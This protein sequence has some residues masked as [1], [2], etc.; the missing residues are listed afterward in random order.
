MSRDLSAIFNTRRF[1]SSDGVLIV[2]DIAGPQ[3]A[4]MVVLM[5]G[6]GQTRHSWSGTFEMLGNAGY[7][8]IA[9]DARGH[10]ESGWST[11]GSYSY[12]IRAADL[13]AVLADTSGPFV[14]VGASMG[15]VTGMQAVGE[16]VRPAALVLVDIV[17]APEKAGVDRIRNFMLGN[18]DGFANLEAVV[19]AVAAYSPHRPRPRNT[20]GLMR[21]LREGSDGRLRWH[22]DPR[23]LPPDS[24]DDLSRIEDVVAL[25]RSS[26]DSPLLLVRGMQSDVLSDASVA[27][28]LQSFPRAEVLDVAGAGHMVA[29]DSNDVFTKGIVEYLRKFLPVAAK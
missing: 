6:G 25:F 22:W 3:D 15:G 18:P 12:S 2:A 5:H 24:R 26:S 10:G 27:H 19:D 4:P 23:I 7:R 16:G 17:L 29:G 20:Q 14:L 21:N 11:E 28:F 9:Y 1:V 8:V 13:R